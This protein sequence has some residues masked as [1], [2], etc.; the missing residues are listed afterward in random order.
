MELDENQ[1]REAAERFADNWSRPK[2]EEAEHNAISH[3]YLQGYK[4]AWTKAQGE[5]GFYGRA[6]ARLQ[7]KLAIA[8]RALE[9]LSATNIYASQALAKIRGEHE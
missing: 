4:A 3:S 8:D 5:P 9:N 7:Q 1:M 2:P 6:A